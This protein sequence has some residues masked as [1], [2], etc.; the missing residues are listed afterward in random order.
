M[1]TDEDAK[2]FG[3]AIS[4]VADNNNVSVISHGWLAPGHPDPRGRR[5]TDIAL[6]SNGW[7]FWD[8]LSL[9]QVDAYGKRTQPEEVSFRTALGSMHEVYANPQWK[10]L[11]ILS[12]PADAENKIPYMR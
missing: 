5:R 7:V 10:V 12:I 3:V 4:A 8:F 2:A 9:F 1:G 11:R 6:V